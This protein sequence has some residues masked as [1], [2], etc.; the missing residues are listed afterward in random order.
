MSLGLGQIFALLAEAPS[1]VAAGRRLAGLYNANKP[2]V[3]ADIAMAKEVLEVVE[4]HKHLLEPNLKLM[5]EV[6]D[7]YEMNKPAL[8]RIMAILDDSSPNPLPAPE[9]RERAVEV[10]T[11]AA[12]V[13]TPVE[14]QAGVRERLESA[15]APFDREANV[16]R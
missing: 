10:L 16:D 2:L 3:D 8:D 6:L 7:A 4:R 13:D 1:G 9:A 14:E 15:F 11:S 12:V 5:R